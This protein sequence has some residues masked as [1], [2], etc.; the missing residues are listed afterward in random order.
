MP[1]VK[2]VSIYSKPANIPTPTDVETPAVKPQTQ[3]SVPPVAAEPI[4][5]ETPTT[6]TEGEP[7]DFASCWNK[8]FTE[9]FENDHIIFHSFKDE[10]PQYEDD[11]IRIVLKNNIQ[12]EQFET[13]KKSI[14]EYWRNHYTL[15][16][17]DIEFIV[18]EQ[19]KEKTVIIN[20]EDKFRN[21]KEQNA[22]LVDF[23]NVLG[24]RMKE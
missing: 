14:L 1:S 3:E 9:L 12:K 5:T 16:V 23:L 18:N 11:I 6:P 7:E 19:K 2:E 4:H 15:N 21:M 20:S 22:Q 8:L 24:F 10:T 17:D 13:R